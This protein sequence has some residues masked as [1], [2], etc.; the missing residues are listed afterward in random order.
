MTAL[1][2]IL[3]EQEIVVSMDT[4]ASREDKEPFKFVSKIFPLPHIRT[5][6]CGTGNLE[7]LLN[8][9]III[10]TKIVSRDIEYVDRYAT[11]FLRELD[12][13]YPDELS[14]TVYHFGYSE[15][16]DKLKGYAYRKEKQFESELMVYGIGT[17][18]PLETE[19]VY[20]IFDNNDNYDKA[21]IEMME[22]QKRRDDIKTEDKVGIGGEIQMCV[23]NTNFFT[24][25]IVH[26]FADYEETYRKVMANLRAD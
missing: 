4:L 16:E 11:Q 5:I 13:K 20:T 2:F 24:I 9:H 25:A 12:S 21:L 3:T 19:L 17:K 7:L 15:K 1:N 10:Q 26:R 6:M 22:E 14:A 8:W 18:P 23:M